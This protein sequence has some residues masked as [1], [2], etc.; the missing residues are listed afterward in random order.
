MLSHAGRITHCQPRD[1]P[2]VWKLSPAFDPYSVE[3][4]ARI[5][6]PSCARFPEH[7][8]HAGFRC[9][10]LNEPLRFGDPGI[11]HE[12]SRL[13]GSRPVLLIP[14]IPHVGQPSSKPSSLK[15]QPWRGTFIPSSP[16][17]SPSSAAYLTCFPRCEPRS[18]R[19]FQRPRHPPHPRLRPDH[20]PAHPTRSP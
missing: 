9:A 14:R 5:T 7:N 12:F 8:R 15:Y 20:R 13:R 2:F 17:F 19:P 4:L 10:T 18:H 6:L 1:E 11:P 3:H 16:N